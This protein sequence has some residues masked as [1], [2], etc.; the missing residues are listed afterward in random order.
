MRVW[1]DLTKSPDVLVMQVDVE[2]RAEHNGL[3][4]RRDPR[5]LVTLLLSATDA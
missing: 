5:E 1:V 4:I 3:R 2:R